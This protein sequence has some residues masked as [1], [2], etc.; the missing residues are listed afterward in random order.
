M[1]NRWRRQLLF[2]LVL[3]ALSLLLTACVDPRELGQ[4]AGV[5]FRQLVGMA[6]QFLFGFIE[7]CCRGATASSAALIMLAFIFTRR[8]TG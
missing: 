3:C 7:G 4:Q 2:I 8:R 6:Q 1:V 5:L